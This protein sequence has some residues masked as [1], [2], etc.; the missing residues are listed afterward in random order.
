MSRG[1]CA[2]V[3]GGGGGGAGRADTGVGAPSPRGV[4][5]GNPLGTA[6]RAA[7]ARCCSRAPASLRRGMFF[8][9]GISRT[10]GGAVAVACSRGRICTSDGGGRKQLQYPPGRGKV[11]RV[12]DNPTVN[13]TTIVTSEIPS[14]AHRTRE[15]PRG[16]FSLSTRELWRH[17]TLHG[18]AKRQ[19]AHCV[20]PVRRVY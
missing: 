17:V 12:K 10:A 7:A 16:S 13:E 4:W 8:V 15:Q 14:L 20:A 5:L 9:G 6:A 3:V 2:G 1:A 19:R 18:A 11:L